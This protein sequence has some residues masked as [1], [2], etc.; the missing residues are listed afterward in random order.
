MVRR[1]ALLVAAIAGSLC[2]AAEFDYARVEAPEVLIFPTPREASYGPL[3][4]EISGPEEAPAVVVLGQDAGPRVEVAAEDLN[5]D[6]V[7]L[8]PDAKP[9]EVI[10]GEALPE[11]AATVILLGVAGRNALLDQALKEAGLYI[12]P[13]EPGPEGYRIAV[14]ERNGRKLVLLAGCDEQGAYWAARSFGQLM[15]RTDDGRVK[16]HRAA[17]RDWPA[18]AIRMTALQTERETPEI[19][20][21]RLDSALRMRTNTSCY[22][23]YH[24]DA[25]AWAMRRGFRTGCGYWTMQGIGR[26]AGELGVHANNWSNKE[27]RDA[28]SDSYRGSAGGRPGLVIYHDCTDAGWWN[29]YLRDFWNQR[30]DEDRQAYPQDHPAVADADRINAIHKAVKEVSGETDVYITIPCYYDSPWNDQ[31]ENVE[32]FRDYLRTLGRLTPNDIVWVLEDRSPMD[33]LSY[34]HYLEG[35]FVNYKYPGTGGSLWTTTFASAKDFVGYTDAWWY[36]VGGYNDSLT[37]MGGAEYMW[38]PDQPTDYEYLTQ[39]FVPRACRFMFGRAWREMADVF[40]NLGF[41]HGA[42][43]EGKQIALVRKAQGQ[44]DRML[45]QLEAADARIEPWLRDGKECIGRIRAGY[46]P[47]REWLALRLSL[48]EAAEACQRAEMLLAFSRFEEATKILGEAAGHLA[49]VDPQEVKEYDWLVK[50]MEETKARWERLDELAASGDTGEA[51]AVL[52]LD[53]TWRFAT[54]PENKGVDRKWEGPET[55]RS[56]WQEI[57][58]PSRFETSGL[59]GMSNYDGYA[60]YARDFELPPAWKGKKIVLHIGAADDEAWV[61]LNGEL[62]GDHLEKDYPE[63][64]WEASFEFDITERIRWNGPNHLVVRLYDSHLEG[65]IWKSVFIRAE[66]PEGPQEGPGLVEIKSTVDPNVTDK[67]NSHRSGR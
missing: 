9:L 25:N 67:K 54:D 24:A 37:M 30:S 34:R 2:Q 38:N 65:G 19:R 1:C 16:A 61:Y 20:L 53:G 55:D 59:P 57:G 39:V 4:L 31:L 43:Q 13:T 8:L 28:W 5:R 66:K 50:D 58:V 10:H 23:G 22:S 40:V 18:F 36:C 35:R 49:K 14:H 46:A 15:R 62:I 11:G 6:I 17:V 44:L 51:A 60:W 3:D 52:S 21:L 12:T 26:K 63:I 29:V 42:V 56:V 48:T 32:L 47:V 45:A 7:N 33:V 27:L 41:N 64:W